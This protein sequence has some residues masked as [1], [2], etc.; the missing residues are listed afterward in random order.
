MLAEIERGEQRD[1][2]KEV[3]MEERSAF[4]CLLQTK[5]GFHLKKGRVFL[6]ISNKLGFD[7]KK[8]RV[9]LFVS[10]ELGF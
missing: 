10:K 1:C 8:G 2:A 9:F 3:T 5:L 6:F 7:L 4:L